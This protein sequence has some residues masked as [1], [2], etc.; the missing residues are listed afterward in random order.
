MTVYV[1]NKQEGAVKIE[2]E[3][4]EYKVYPLK[5]VYWDDVGIGMQR[6]KEYA[7]EWSD[8]PKETWSY[9]P[10]EEQDATRNPETLVDFIDSYAHFKL[11]HTD[12]IERKKKK[13]KEVT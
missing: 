11:S 12:D 13:L 5:N 1:G 3:G 4:E 10:Y 8:T 2:K 6:H 7:F 9:K